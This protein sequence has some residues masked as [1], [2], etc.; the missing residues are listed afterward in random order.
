MSVIAAALKHMLAAGMPHDAIVH[1]VAEM[2]ASAA[3]QKTARQL[4][5]AR[6]YAAKA[7]EKR[8]KAS[9]QDVSDDSVLKP[10]RVRVED[11]TSNSEIE[12]QLENKKRAT[13][14]LDGFEDWYRAYPH[15]V[16]RGAAERA[17]PKARSLASQSELIEGLR[18]YVASKPVDRPWQNPATWLNGKGWLDQPGQVQS[19]ASPH[20]PASQTASQLLKARRQ[21]IF[22]DERPTDRPYLIV[23]R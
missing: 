8:L 6:Y 1:A 18:R 11:K 3:P 7:S 12:P 2:E 16:Q 14:A 22:D 23:A 19:R 13:S 5:N 10:S 4:R 17:W 15:K 20:F 9:E 21:E